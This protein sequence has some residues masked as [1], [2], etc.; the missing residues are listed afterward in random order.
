MSQNQNHEPPPPQHPFEVTI[1]IGANEWPYVLEALD[2]IREQIHRAGEAAGMASGGWHGCH[3][4][5][6][7]KRDITPEAY[8]QELEN[9]HKAVR[10]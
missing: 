1:H 5:T 3:S 6:V 10:A 8:R 7:A 2:S 4:V 9:W